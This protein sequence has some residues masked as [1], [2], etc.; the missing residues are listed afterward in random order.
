MHTRFIC[1]S[2]Q[3]EYEAL[4]YWQGFVSS[5]WKALPGTNSTSRALASTVISLKVSGTSSLSHK[6]IPPDG[7]DHSA[8]PE[9]DNKIYST[10]DSFTKI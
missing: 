4:T 7:S 1:S 3:V 8:N 2:E 6:N 9:N 5:N 10:G